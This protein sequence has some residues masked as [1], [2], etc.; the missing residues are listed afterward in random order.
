M[1][2]Y[3]CLIQ[4]KDQGTRNIQDTMKRADAAMAEA[5]QTGMKIVEEFWTM[6]AYDGAIIIETPDVETMNGSSL[7]FHLVTSKPKPCARFAGTRCK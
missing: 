1:L 2:G 6:G 7:R 4:F 5:K 3:V